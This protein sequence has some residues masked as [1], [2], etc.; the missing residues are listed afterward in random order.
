MV[1]FDSAGG[2]RRWIISNHHHGSWFTGTPVRVFI[3]MRIH[4]LIQI[5]QEAE[6]QHGNLDCQVSL[7]DSHGQSLYC[8]E[9]PIVELER[10]AEAGD[11]L[12]VRCGH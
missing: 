6:K 8:S 3:T 1:E 11:W 4:E 5:L 12:H 10:D 7:R 9:T 2:D